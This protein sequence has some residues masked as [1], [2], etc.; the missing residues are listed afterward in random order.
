MF[1]RTTL[2]SLRSSQHALRFA[3]PITRSTLV[4]NRAFATE[5]ATEPPVAST[6]APIPQ[7]ASQVTPKQTR[8]FDPTVPPTALLRA[9]IHP[10]THSIPVALI[11]LRSPS[12][13]LLS[14]FTH[15]AMHAA[16]GF[17]IPISHTATLPTQRSLYTVLK[18]PFVHKKAQENFER[19]I[20]KRAIKAWDADGEVVGKWIKYLELHA[21]GGV[22]MRVVRWERVE[23]GFGKK[24][25]E[26]AGAS[27][28]AP[29]SVE[30]QVKALSEQIVADEMKA[31]GFTAEAAS[32]PESSGGA[33][34][35]EINKEADLAEKSTS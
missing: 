28:R 2:A 26:Q 35:S 4:Y 15:F 20:S 7:P 1:S 32:A 31:A 3:A 17:G 11:H 22:G 23:L 8:K 19:K 34:E 16:Y 9:P 29:A 33:G 27:L 13:A 21:M 14:L 12:P 6:S 30:D 18:S 25:L 10:R 5:A 24:R